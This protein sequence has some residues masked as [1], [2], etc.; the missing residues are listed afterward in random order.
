M[1]NPGPFQLPGDWIPD[2]SVCILFS[3]SSRHRTSMHRASNP[4]LLPDP[5]PNLAPPHSLS[6]TPCPK[7]H[8]SP[9]EPALFTY[10]PGG[11]CCC[12]TA[13][14]TGSGC[15]S[16]L[17]VA[18]TSCFLS[19]DTSSLPV[20]ARTC[21]SA[22]AG[23]LPSARNAPSPCMPAVHQFPR[24]ACW[25]FSRAAS[26]ALQ[27]D[28]VLPDLE[29]QVVT[30]LTTVCRCVRLTRTRIHSAFAHNCA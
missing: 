6:E 15:P 22:F 23:T 1:N 27:W 14:P 4:E 3:V 12:P 19:L 8:S 2:S 21:H 18:N 5:A 17:L 13:V 29:A 16:V 7:Y 10:L 26:P 25:D 30:A 20:E 24:K 28:G 9:S 11:R